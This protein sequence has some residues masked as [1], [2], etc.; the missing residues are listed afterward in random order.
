MA[1][2]IQTIHKPTRA[3]ALDTSGNN[4]HGQI[5]SGRG[6]DFDGVT[7]FLTCGTNVRPENTIT[8]S[9]WGKA[10]DASNNTAIGI[11]TTGGYETKVTISSLNSKIEF[12]VLGTE[13]GGDGTEVVVDIGTLL[14]LT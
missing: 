8:F 6:L 14:A 3:R 13:G 4:N 9:F 1:A 7:D 12:T 2:T 5:Y 11:Y 10:N